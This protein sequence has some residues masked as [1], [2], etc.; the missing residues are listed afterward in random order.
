[1]AILVVSALEARRRPGTLPVVAAC[2]AGVA[3]T[4]TL[5]QFGIAF[6]AMLGVLVLQAGARRAAAVGLV[7][8]LIAILAW[9]APHLGEVRSASQVEADPHTVFDLRCRANF[10]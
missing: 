3:G 6:V 10:A 8:S 1:M 5:P 2:A 7:A 4:G 9:Y